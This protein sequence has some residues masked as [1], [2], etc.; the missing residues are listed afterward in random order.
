[1]ADDLRTFALIVTV[2]PFCAAIHVATSRHVIHCTCELRKKYK[3][4]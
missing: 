2:N 3:K 1:M 4:L